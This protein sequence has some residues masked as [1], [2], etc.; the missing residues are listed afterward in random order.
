MGIAAALEVNMAIA[1]GAVVSGTFLGDKI[2]PLSDSV[3]LAAL[4]SETPLYDHIKHLFYTTIPVV[5]IVVIAY[6]VIGLTTQHPTAMVAGNVNKILTSLNTIFSW[7]ILLLL[8]PLIVIYGAIREK[9]ALPCLLASSFVAALIAKFM[10]GFSLQSI[11]NVV[12]TGFN[13]SMVKDKGLAPEQITPAVAKLISQGGLIDIFSVLM[14][15]FS[16]FAFAGIISK[17]G[18]LDV[19]GEKILT[20][21]KSDGSLVL[22][23][24]LTSVATL[25][26]MGSIY[27]AII[28]PGEIFKESYKKH[29]LHSKN[30]SRALQESSSVVAPL[31]PWSETGAYTAATLGMATAEFLPWAFV[32]YLG[33]MLTILFAFTGFSMKKTE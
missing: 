29:R 32:S 21:A 20:K 31:I 25:M 2:S 13:I 11:C 30:L 9:P 8:P 1:A 16:A 23:A 3:N 24:V 6:T 26:V 28:I 15:L 7:N 12:M 17:A 27:L 5:L 19:I 22:T 18:C 10:Q 14:I 33:A 4:S